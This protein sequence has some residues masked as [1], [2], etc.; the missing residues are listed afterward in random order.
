MPEKGQIDD[1]RVLTQ[2]VT[3]TTAHVKYCTRAYRDFFG[4]PLH[5]FSTFASPENYQLMPYTTKRNL[6]IL[7]PDD[8][9]KNDLLIS[10]LAEKD[11]KLEIKV[12]RNLKY[13]EY[14]ELISAA[15]WSVTFG[16]G[17]DFYFIEPVFSGAI[18]FAI[19]ND[20]F[21]T[22]DFSSLRT[23]YHSFD[24]L[25]ENL[26]EDIGGLDSQDAF[27]RVQKEEFE[28]CAKYYSK[29]QYRKNIAA[30]YRR[31]YTYA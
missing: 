6:M 13:E 7:S 5:F 1:L 22:P 2:N 19:Y 11:I 25:L 14:K 24:E 27:S 8:P 28:L 12:I 20:Q 29:E 30:F 4:A 3:I 15:K 9:K 21:F 26:S 16:E 18:S 17:L 31:E 10:K 23:V